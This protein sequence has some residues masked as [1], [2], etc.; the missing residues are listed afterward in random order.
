MDERLRHIVS[1]V[2]A[3]DAQAIGDDAS[4]AT[5]DSWDSLRHMSLIVAIEDEF[6]MRFDDRVLP[7]LVTFRG[8]REAVVGLGSP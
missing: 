4:P 5:I 2:L 3:I 8:I 7:S 1:Q 6:E